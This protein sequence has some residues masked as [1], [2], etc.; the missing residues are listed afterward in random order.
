MC[1]VQGR[2]CRVGDSPRWLQAP[3]G[4]RL[5]RGC[6]GP[7]LWKATIPS[8]IGASRCKGLTGAHLAR[9][10]SWGHSSPLPT[11]HLPPLPRR[12]LVTIPVPEEGP[13]VPQAPMLI[14]CTWRASRSLGR[15]PERGSPT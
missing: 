12:G 4:L 8:P 11:L 14:T 15:S 1:T 10:I 5:P 9:F 3:P 2:G 6:Q 7:S 13:A